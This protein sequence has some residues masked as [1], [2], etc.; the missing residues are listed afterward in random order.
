LQEN[1]SEI[2]FISPHWNPSVEDQA[3]A[4]CHRIGQTKPVYVQ[5]FEMTPF[6]P[7]HDDK[8]LPITTKTIDK[9][10]LD[11]QEGKRIVASEIVVQ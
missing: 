10:V 11:V 9:Y 6:A 8:G 2:Y 4:R 5:R 1:Y 3:I 7:E